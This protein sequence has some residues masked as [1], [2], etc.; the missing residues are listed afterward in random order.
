MQLPLQIAFRNLERTDALEDDVRLRAE[1]LDD[2]CDS[3][4]GCR[5]V[6]EVP[7]RHHQRGNQYLVRIDLTVPGEEI[8]VN[9]EPP[10]HVEYRDLNVALRDAFDTARRLLEDHV[11]RRRGDVKQRQAPVHARVSKL[12]PEEGF[13]FLETPEGRE[14]YFHRASVLDGG[15]G[16]LTPGTE[17]SFAEEEGRKGPQASTVKIT[18]RH[19]HR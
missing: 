9:R 12:F 7:H 5:V 2:F 8:V 18:G 16:R 19:G 17:V 13:G 4:M 3:I 15:F 11:R 6:V 14:V 10:V 1:I